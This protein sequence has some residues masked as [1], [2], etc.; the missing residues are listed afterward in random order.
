MITSSKIRPKK[1][2]EIYSLFLEQIKHISIEQIVYITFGVYLF[3]TLLAYTVIP[4]VIHLINMPLKAIRY[5]CYAIFFYKA[6]IDI[7]RDQ[8]ISLT[9]VVFSILSILSFIF[10]RNQITLIFLCIMI[11]LRKLNIH[12]LVKIAYYTSLATFLSIITL[13]LFGVIPNWVFTRGPIIR[14]SIGF[15]FATDC[16]SIYLTIILMFFYLKRSNAKMSEIVLLEVLNLFLYKATDGRLS[17]ILI[18]ILLAILIIYKTVKLIQAN[19]KKRH[20][21]SINNISQRFQQKFLQNHFIQAVAKTICCLLPIA[22]FTLYNLLT[23]AYM[24]NPHDMSKIDY[25][26]SSRLKYTAQAYEKY[27]I[28][29]FGKNI[30]WQ[31]WGGYGYT[32]KINV[33][34]FEYN[35]VDSSYARLIFD[36][37]IIYTLSILIAYAYSLNYYLKR[38]DYWALL[39]IVF[40]IIWSFIEPY[41]ID[42]SR[43][44]LIILLIPTLEL[45]PTLHLRN[46]KDNQAQKTISNT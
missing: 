9:T 28:P 7:K 43:N 46:K 4:E 31:G 27:Q 10:S 42:M 18:T 8:K 12:K 19:A 11:G 1:T 29:L 37:G 40:I 33:E 35:F 20:I 16:I 41:M 38:R 24:S 23:T 3:T 22:L 5:I 30:A 15:V 45:G 13:S 32:D 2:K 36:F 39:V 6:F 17:F 26:L 34:Q 14:N 21:V 44:P 25:M